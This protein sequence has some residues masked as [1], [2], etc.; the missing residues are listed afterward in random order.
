MI[1]MKYFKYLLLFLVILAVVGGGVY[2]YKIKNKESAVI[3]SPLA[4]DD[5]PKTSAF[6]IE[7]APTES[8]RGKIATMS[9]EIN[10]QGRIATEASKI[11]S[12]MTIQQGE[13]LI[14]KDVS[15]L[16]LVF[17][18]A[19]S[20]EFSPDTEIEVVQT[21]PQNIVFSQANGTAEYI[22]TGSFPISVRAISLLV[23]SD[24]DMTVSIDPEKPI[25]TLDL[26]SGKATA[27]YNDL[28]Y[29]SHEVTL[30]AGQTFTFND[31][32]RKGVLR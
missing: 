4:K 20:V 6:S 24:G 14:T 31:G 26:K 8:L 16:S 9:G 19:C 22:K 27:A 32:T 28:K 18:D 23:E 1:E 5:A 2:L 21:L 11:S 17:A 12:P 3:I 15:T 25:I 7:N 29:V 13:K 10:W 30:I